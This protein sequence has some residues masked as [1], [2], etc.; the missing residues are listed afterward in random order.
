MYGLLFVDDVYYFIVCVVNNVELCNCLSFDG[1][2]I[3]FSFLSYG[4]VYDGII[5]LDFKY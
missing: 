4:V 3:D 1:V 2:L 5:E